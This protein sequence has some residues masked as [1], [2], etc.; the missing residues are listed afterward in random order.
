LHLAGYDDID[1]Q[2]TQKMRQREQYYL[3]KEIKT[4]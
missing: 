3:E 4:Y 1:D 2:S